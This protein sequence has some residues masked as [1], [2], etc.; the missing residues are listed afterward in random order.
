MQDHRIAGN[1]RHRAAPRGP[2]DETQRRLLLEL[3]THPPPQGDRIDDLAR[4]LDE[5]LKDIEAAVDA[6]AHAGL[7]QRHASTVRASAAALRFEALWPTV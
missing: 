6:L 4:L 1:S 7:A 2:S 3:V 5:P